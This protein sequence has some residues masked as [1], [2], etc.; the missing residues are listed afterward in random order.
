MNSP[1]S[2]SNPY[3][4]ELLQR[5]E[6]ELVTLRR[7]A[8]QTDP[9]V[10]RIGLAFSGGGIRSATFHLGVLQG[11]AQARLLRRL[12]LRNLLHKSPVV[13]F[14]NLLKLPLLRRYLEL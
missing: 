12:V 5:T 2:S 8:A 1:E 9:A 10:P 13:Q 14:V 11:L 3:Y 7:R 6:D 4:P